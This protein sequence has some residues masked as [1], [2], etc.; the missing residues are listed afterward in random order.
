MIAYELATGD[1]H[2]FHAKAVVIA[3]AA[4]AASAPDHVQHLT[5]DGIVFP[6]GTSLSVKVFS[7]TLP[8]C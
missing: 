2:V 8:A 5:G 3:T 4:R 1:I 7:F 6:Q